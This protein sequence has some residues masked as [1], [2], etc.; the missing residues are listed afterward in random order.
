[1]GEDVREELSTWHWGTWEGGKGMMGEGAAL[2]QARAFA[3][4][5]SVS[6]LAFLPDRLPPV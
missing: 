5:E 4:A 2:V 3:M 6:G 1:M